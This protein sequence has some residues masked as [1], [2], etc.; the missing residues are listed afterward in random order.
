M[1]KAGLIRFAG[2]LQTD[3]KDTGI[4]TFAIH[5]GQVKNTQLGDIN[6]V[7]KDYIREAAPE[8]PKLIGGLLDQILDCDPR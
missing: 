1:S 5:P 6:Y 2:S 3:L 4:C 8:I 7:V